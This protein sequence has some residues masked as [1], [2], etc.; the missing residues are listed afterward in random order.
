MKQD[1]AECGKSCQHLERYSPGPSWNSRWLVVK[2]C[3]WVWL[4]KP[5]PL[6]ATVLI[7]LSLDWTNTVTNEGNSLELSLNGPANSAH[8]C[9]GDSEKV[10]PAGISHALKR[11]ERSLKQGALVWSSMHV[12]KS[13]LL[14]CSFR[15]YSEQEYCHNRAEVQVSL[16]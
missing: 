10:L 13:I 11:W 16:R 8:F 12:L 6:R 5:A 1:Q 9:L 4:Q 3:Q 15:S 2:R 7:R 14:F